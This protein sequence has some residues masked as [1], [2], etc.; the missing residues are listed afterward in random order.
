MAGL[1]QSRP[2]PN[3]RNPSQSPIAEGDFNLHDD[4]SQFKGFGKRLVLKGRTKDQTN[5]LT[6]SGR[7]GRIFG[8][9]AFLQSVQ[10]REVYF[11]GTQVTMV[12]T[13]VYPVNL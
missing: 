12:K 9:K 3:D 11:D 10:Q 2:E 13:I 1:R 5:F 4:G 7:N 8:S 6:A